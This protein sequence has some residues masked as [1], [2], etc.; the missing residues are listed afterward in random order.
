VFRIHL[1]HVLAQ[2]LNLYVSGTC[3]EDVANLQHSEAVRGIIGACRIPD[4]TTAGDFLR[5]LH[6]QEYQLPGLRRA[7]DG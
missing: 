1:H 3:I 6:E 7:V 5:R 4:P 2:T